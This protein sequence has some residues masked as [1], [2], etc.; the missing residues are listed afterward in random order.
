M[1]A[2]S[3]N[4]ILWNRLACLGLLGQAGLVA[5]VSAGIWL[6]IS[7][8]A[9]Q[10]SGAAGLAAAAVGGGICF[11]GAALAL[12]LAVPFPGPDAV[13]HRMALGMLARAL[14]PLSLGVALHFKAP[15]LAQAGM[16]FY[17]L[18]FYMATLAMET[19]LMLAQVPRA[20]ATDK[21]I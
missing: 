3:R 14:V 2:G 15:A 20:S 1:M 7:P 18:V 9:Y 19:L 5:A 8:L 6:I 13:M 17:L 10:L 12:I 21:S 16:V 11:M 4:T